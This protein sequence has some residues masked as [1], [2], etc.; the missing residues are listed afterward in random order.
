MRFP[1][2]AYEAMSPATANIAPVTSCSHCRVVTNRHYRSA[3]GPYTG[4]GGG[5]RGG[6]DRVVAVRVDREVL[7][8]VGEFEQA[9]DRALGR[10]DEQPLAG[11]LELI[12]R[13]DDDAERGRVDERGAAQVEDD[14][15][16]RAG[17]AH[18]EDGR[19]LG[20]GCDIELAR[21]R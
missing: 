13:T 20:G 10:D 11:A 18:R 8:E 15:R 21:G 3:T 9:A 2:R 5:E 4:S 7:L 12:G 14:N 6:G 1:G 16:L 17:R 19:E